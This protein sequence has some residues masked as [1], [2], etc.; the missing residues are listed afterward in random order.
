MAK[1]RG[2]NGD[3][4]VGY[5]TDIHTAQKN[6][7]G[8]KAVDESG[9]EYSYMQGVASTLDGSWVTFDEAHLTTLAAANGQGRVA[10]AKAAILATQFGWYQLYG[11]TS[12]LCLTGFVDNGK[13]YLTA[14]AGSVDDA[15]VAAD[16]VVGAVGR[17][18][19]DTVTGMATF[20]LSYPMVQD[21]AF[22]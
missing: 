8:Q 21:T 7:L 17:S 2:A 18:A 22:D 4:V 6:R 3:G 5:L 11:S 14:T 19:R 12:A 15:D 9:N 13:V 16:F 1:L 10:V 20:E